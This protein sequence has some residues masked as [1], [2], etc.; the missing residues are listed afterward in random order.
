[1]LNK[2]FQCELA[3][4]YCPNVTIG[5]CMLQPKLDGCRAWAALVNGE[6]QLFT[7]NGN[8]INGCTHIKQELSQIL[9]NSNMVLDGELYSHG[10]TFQQI[11]KQVKNGGEQLQFWAFDLVEDNQSGYF[12]RYNALKSLIGACK[13]VLCVNTL[14]ESKSDL[15]AIPDALQRVL[16]DGYE[17]LIIRTDAAHVNGRGN[18]IWKLK[19]HQDAEFV[20]KDI[21]KAL[22][23]GF[24]AVL[25][26]EEGK[27]F[28]AALCGN[29]SEQ[30]AIYYKRARWI[31]KQATVKFN[32]YTD[33]GL[34]R[35][36]KMVAIRNYE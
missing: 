20:V 33:A 2:T 19:P 29:V 31:N 5:A 8:L 15:Y 23:G 3:K 27:V 10:L 26:N 18:G 17:G 36:A 16:K 24:V 12:A 11:I 9:T 34:P 13:H 14:N 6:V 35:F 21:C 28:K 4:T 25:C 7:R 30:R 1:M 22:K 32:G